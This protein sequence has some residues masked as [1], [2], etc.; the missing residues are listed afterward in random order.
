MFHQ[1]VNDRQ[2]HTEPIPIRTNAKR[3][4]ERGIQAGDVGLHHA[5]GDAGGK[6]VQRGARMFRAVA[7]AMGGQGGVGAHVGSNDERVDDPGGGAGVRKPL[8]SPRRHLCQRECRAA[9][10][11]RDRRG[12]FNIRR[13]ITPHPGRVCAKHIQ[14]LIAAYEFAIGTGHAQV[15]GDRL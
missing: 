7:G 11:A 1:P 12:L 13:G 14:D 4:H 8:V 6:Q 3:P 15:P 9:H 2:Q 10:D 5:A